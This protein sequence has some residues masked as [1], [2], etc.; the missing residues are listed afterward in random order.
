[1]PDQ[2][3]A[4]EA[5]QFAAQFQ[6]FFRWVH[7]AAPQEGNE[8]SELV[9]DFLGPEGTRHSVV[10]RELPRFEHVN[11]QTAIDDSPHHSLLNRKQ[12]AGLRRADEIERRAGKLEEW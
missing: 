11:L 7:E 5:R 1:M 8:V 10:T 2:A 9:R 3:P 4:E 12:I 6:R